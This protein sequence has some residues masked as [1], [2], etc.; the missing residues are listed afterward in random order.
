MPNIYQFNF[1]EFLAFFLILL[2]ISGFVVAWPIFGVAMVPSPAK[3]LFAFVLALI[4]FPVVDWKAMPIHTSLESLSIIWLSIKEIF[5]GLSFGYLARMFFYVMEVAGELI[6]LSMG[7]SSVQLFNPAMGERSSAT[8]QF[9]IIL[10]TLF[11]LAINGHHI[12]LTGLQQSF[13]LLPLSESGLNFSAY[14]HFGSLLQEIVLIGLKM[15][16][17]VMISIFFMNIALAIIGRAVPQINVLIT[18]LPVNI[19]V[20]FIVMFITLPFVVYQ[21]SDLLDNTATHMF[22]LLKDY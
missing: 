6:S 18:S 9:F 10:A 21:M 14:S 22:Q 3:I 16:M 11:F 5:I 1:Y 15:S 13:Q 17:P 12:L 8:S 7:I 2:R 4:L 20:G 19:L